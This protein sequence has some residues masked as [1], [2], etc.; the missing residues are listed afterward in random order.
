MLAMLNWRSGSHLHDP[1]TTTYAVPNEGTYRG[2][3]NTCAQGDKLVGLPL[4]LQTKR[5]VLRNC[6]ENREAHLMRGTWWHLLAR[7]LPQDENAPVRGLE[8]LQQRRRASCAPVVRSP[9][10]RSAG[11][12][13]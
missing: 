11:G 9:R 8:T 3:D 12:G 13:I 7:P 1:H 10:P 4:D 2:C 5:S 6:L